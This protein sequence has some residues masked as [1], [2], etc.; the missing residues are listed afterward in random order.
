M[1]IYW[2]LKSV[3]E[4]APLTR[5]QRR[6]VH[7][8]CLRRHFFLA[9]AT[10]RS[11]LAYGAALLITSILVFL[12]ASISAGSGITRSV[13]LIVSAL[14]GFALGRFVLSRIAVPVLRPFY[15]EFIE[16]HICERD[17]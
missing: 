14:V 11:V 2:S 9:R 7:E 17:V 5:K 3:P 13:W 6:R 10:A 12:G 8:Q 16:G 15:R 1:S 4:L